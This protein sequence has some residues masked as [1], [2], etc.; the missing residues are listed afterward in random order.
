MVNDLVL[1]KMSLK[2]EP[3]PVCGQTKIIIFDKV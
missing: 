3:L 2:L 1:N